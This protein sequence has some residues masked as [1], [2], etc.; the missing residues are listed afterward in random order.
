MPKNYKKT[1]KNFIEDIPD[2]KLEESIGSNPIYKDVNMRLDNQGIFTKDDK[3]YYNF[4]VQ[5]NKGCQH[6]TLV[7]FECTK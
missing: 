7:S 6:K 1:I 4:Q 3:K 2:T 5:V